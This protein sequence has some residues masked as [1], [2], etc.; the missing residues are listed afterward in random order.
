M[1]LLELQKQVEQAKKDNATQPSTTNDTTTN[2]PAQSTTPNQPT[3][4]TNPPTT[5]PKKHSYYEP[6]YERSGSF[7][8]IELGAGEVKAIANTHQGS[9]EDKKKGFKYGIL[10]GYNKF[11]VKYFG[12]RAYLN[13]SVTQPKD[14]GEYLYRLNYGAN[15][16]LLANFVATNYVDFGAFVGLGA[17]GQTWLFTGQSKELYDTLESNGVEV[18]YTGFDV[19]LNVGLRSNIAQHLGLE[20]AARIPF[21]KTNIFDVSYG[22]TYSKLQ[23]QETYSISARLLW[24]F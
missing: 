15:V 2:P 7:I 10:W 1:R 6:P 24:N 19:G 20:V 11:F 18:N 16:D 12:I 21:V 9:G 4:S 22:G 5:P 13:A 17:G 23:M 8:G 14:Q 3:K